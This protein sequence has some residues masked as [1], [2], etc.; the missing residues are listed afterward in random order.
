MPSAAAASGVAVALILPAVQASREAAARNSDANNLHEIGAGLLNYEDAHNRFPARA[1]F[2]KEGKPLLS[3]R[4]M[5]LPELEEAELYKQFHLDEPWDS[6]NNKKLLDKMPAVFKHQKLDKPGVTVYQAV[7]GKGFAFEGSEGT[8]LASFTDG[9]SRTI[10]VVEAAPERAVPWTKPGDWSPDLS[11]PTVGLGGLAAS[12][13]ANF[14][15]ADAHVE[16]I[17]KPIDAKLFKALLTRNGGEP[18]P[19]R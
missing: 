9:T 16:S 17:A 2:D 3:W 6:E 4:V 1:I 7:V 18:I 15:F 5:I 19:A 13:V 10:L 8:K 14:V 12:N 11:D